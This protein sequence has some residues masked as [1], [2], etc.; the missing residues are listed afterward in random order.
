MIRDQELLDQLLNTLSRFVRERLIPNKARL[1]EEDAVPAEIFA[2]M[3]D[4]GLFG[5][6][7]PVEYG[8]LGLTMESTPQV[9][10]LVIARNMIRGVQ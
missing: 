9:Q 10:Q 8:G 7:I 2:E 6:P 5:L 1:A 4:I 3:K